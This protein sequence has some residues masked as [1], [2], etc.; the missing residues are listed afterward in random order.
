[1]AAEMDFRI[2]GGTYV[3]LFLDPNAG[4]TYA[5]VTTSAQLVWATSVN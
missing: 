5:L 4:P 1:M 2:R 3:N